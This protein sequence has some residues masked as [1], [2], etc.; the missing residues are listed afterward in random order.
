MRYLVTAHKSGTVLVLGFDARGLF[1]ELLIRESPDGI[2][3]Q[4]VIAHIPTVEAELHVRFPSAL[5]KVV[6]LDVEFDDF[7][8]KYLVKVGKKEAHTYWQRMPLVKRQLAFD[9]IER[10]R[11]ICARDRVAPM[12]PATYL[13]AERW[14]D[15][16]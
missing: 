2:T 8:K 10:Y 7:Y 12:Y 4:W 6:P 15:H 1:N 11:G 5:A 16:T 14:L 9:Y 13:R 3:T